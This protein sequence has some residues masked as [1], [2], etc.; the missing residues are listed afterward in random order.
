MYE[1]SLG[2][3]VWVLEINVKACNSV[4]ACGNSG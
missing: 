2:N 1:S 4:E 3:P